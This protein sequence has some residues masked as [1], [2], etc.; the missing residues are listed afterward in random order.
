[1]YNLISIALVVGFIVAA[2][3]LFRSKLNLPPSPVGFP[4]IGHLHLLKGPAHR[5]L[6][7]L[8]QNLGPVF[9]LRL[10][11]CRA[12]V[13]TSASAAEEFLNDVVFANRPIATLGKY[14]GYNGKAL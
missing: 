12:V 13:V 6:R 3:Y 9:F 11:S 2:A 7:D 4:V 10:G 14:I 1:M 8:S 5:C